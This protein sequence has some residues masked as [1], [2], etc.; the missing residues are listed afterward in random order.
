MPTSLK[1]ATGRTKKIDLGHKTVL[2][3]FIDAHTHPAFSGIKHLKMVD[4]DLRSIKEI[5]E[6]ISQKSCHY[7]KRQ[8]G[9]GF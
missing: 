9:G 8:M 7:T 4:C 2:P 3:G 1:L 6:A 5:K